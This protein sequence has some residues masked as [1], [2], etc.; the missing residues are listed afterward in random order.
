[1][2]PSSTSNEVSIGVLVALTGTG[3]GR[4]TIG[5]GTITGSSSTITTRMSSRRQ[6][7]GVVTLAT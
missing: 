1:V 2:A 6:P 7:E 4:A 5:S 3:S